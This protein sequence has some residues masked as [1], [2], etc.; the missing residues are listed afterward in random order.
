MTLQDV[1]GPFGA[2]LDGLGSL[3]ALFVLG[4]L[5]LLVLLAGWALGRR[6]MAPR[7]DPR[8]VAAGYAAGAV[9][10]ETTGTVRPLAPFKADLNSFY[11]RVAQ[12]RARPTVE[13]PLAELV[14]WS[15]H[16]SQVRA[17][18][19]LGFKVRRRERAAFRRWVGPFPRLPEEERE[20]ARKDALALLRLLATYAEDPVGP[21]T[22][23]EMLER[24]GGTA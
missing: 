4:V 21:Q 13:D 2:W 22:I 6:G 8:L 1:L 16:L 18:R 17:F 9:M 14:A 7:M 24:A 11:G 3:A 19:R 23:A 10:T 12:A 5:V 20:E 15:F